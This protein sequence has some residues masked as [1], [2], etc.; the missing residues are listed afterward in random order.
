MSRDAAH[1]LDILLAARKALSFVGDM[2]FETF[3]QDAK[4]QSAVLYQLTIL[5]EAVKRVSDPFR[6]QHP[7]VPWRKMSGTRDRVV[8]AYD[9]VSLDTVWEVLQHDLPELVALLEPLEPKRP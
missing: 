5:G 9:R 7:E 1:V 6:E 2:D 8:H 4:T 3:R